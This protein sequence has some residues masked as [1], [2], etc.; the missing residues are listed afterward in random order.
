MAIA[1]I[2]QRAMSEQGFSFRNLIING[3]MSIAQRG[4][5][6]SSVTTTGYRTCDR[7]NFGLSSG[8][9]WT[10][11]QSTDAPN[12]FSN[13]IKLTNTTAITS[14][15]AICWLKQDIEAQN[16]QHLGYGSSDAKV[17]KL[18]FYVKSNKTGSGTVELRQNDN[19]NKHMTPSYTIN[20]ANTWEYK[21]ITIP[22]DTS[23]VINN[24]NGSG[25]DIRWHLNSGSN[26]NNGT[27]ET[28]WTSFVSANTNPNDLNV[29]DATS[30][31][32]A[33]TGVQLEVGT[34]ASDFEFLPYEV[35]LMRCYRYFF[36]QSS[37]T[38]Q[39]YQSN[40]ND[41]FRR[42]TIFYSVPMR[43][44]PS[45]SNAVWNPTGTPGSQYVTTTSFQMYNNYVNTTTEGSPI[46]YTL[47]AEL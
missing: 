3:D 16:L 46:S 36:K 12:G 47:D 14:A 40:I 39:G 4:T 10:V 30:D 6:V 34:S 41:Q 13:S 7:W 23:G 31:Y 26:Y 33:I 11:E 24:D 25:L 19:G 29:G 17:M 28:T 38:G 9:T 21:T 43:A 8:G 32:F 2:P 27:E 35:N 18:S 37:Q 45:V 20:S 15:G 5:S 44:S 22:A 1:T 42:F